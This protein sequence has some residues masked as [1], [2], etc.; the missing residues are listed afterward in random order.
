MSQRSRIFRF[1]H[2]ALEARVAARDL[3]NARRILRNACRQHLDEATLLDED[4]L[5]LSLHVSASAID[6]DANWEH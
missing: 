4:G 6:E 5:L 3:E 1:R 2:G